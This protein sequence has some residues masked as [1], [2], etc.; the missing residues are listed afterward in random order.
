[1]PIFPHPIDNEEECREAKLDHSEPGGAQLRHEAEVDQEEQEV[2]DM[3]AG[4]AAVVSE[5]GV[6]ME[7]SKEVT[8]NDKQCIEDK[9]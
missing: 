9:V 7:D 3:F 1:M 6:T 8:E 5:D 4:H 2:H